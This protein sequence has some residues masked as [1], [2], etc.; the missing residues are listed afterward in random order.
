[1]IYYCIYIVLA[2]L[3]I[4]SLKIKPKQRILILYLAAI[5]VVLFQSLRWRTG[6]D[7]EPYYICF[8]D[9]LS[10]SNDQFETGYII[11]NKIIRS[12]T[13]NYTFFLIAEC[14]INLLFIVLFLRQMPIS[15]PVLGLLYLFTIAIFPIRYTLASNIILYSYT[16]IIRNKLFPFILLV[17]LAFSIHRTTII[18]IPMFFIVNR[19]YSFKA[20]LTIYISAIVL[21]F[22]SDYTFNKVL[23]LSSSIFYIMGDTVQSKMNAY[24]TQ[25]IPEYGTMSLVRYAIS[26]VNS[27]LFILFFYYYK[28]KYFINDKTYNI[29][30]NLYVLGISFNRIFIQVIPDFARLTSLFTGGFIIMLIMIIDRYNGTKKIIFTTL[31]T[32]YLYLTYSRSVFGIYEDLFIPYYSVFD[33]TQRMYVY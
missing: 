2:I 23:G 10:N 22:A 30:F 26:L 18:F 27:T 32:I 9:S 29:L 6:T 1:M 21:G 24:I 19:Q 12:F 20:I 3:S 4:F 5:F 16:Y 33:S 13:D 14:S 11:L 31:I 25:D 7:W 15:N 8:L 28:K 17:L